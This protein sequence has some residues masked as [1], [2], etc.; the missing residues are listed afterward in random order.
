[1][2]YG[3]NVA[4]M[5]HVV[6]VTPPVDI[7][8]GATTRAFSMKNWS[9]ATIIIQ[10]GAS[11]SAPTSIILNASA[12]SDGSNPVALPFSYYSQTTAGAANDVLSTRTDV[13]ATGITSV[14]ANDG[15]FYV[16]E[17]DA[18]ELPE[19]YTFLD[20]AIAAPAAAIIASVVAILSGGRYQNVASAT[21]TA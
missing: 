9:H 20:I 15:I 7:T 13:A 6:N 16:I 8:G 19:G 14:S 18:T 5:G 3:F 2:P 21:V 11:A 10:I 1:M 12:A 17:V 4:E